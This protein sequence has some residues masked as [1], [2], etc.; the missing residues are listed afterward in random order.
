[1]PLGR[2]PQD[3][4]PSIPTPYAAGKV[5]SS[6]SDVEFSTIQEGVDATAAGG[7][8]VVGPGTYQENVLVETDNIAI[9]T[10]RALVDG[11][12]DY[13]F[14]LLNTTG[15]LV[16]GFRVQ[17]NSGA[18][19]NTST[20]MAQGSNDFQFNAI[21][22]L[23]SGQHGFEDVNSSQYTGKLTR[24]NIEAVDLTCFY[25]QGSRYAIL[26]NNAGFINSSTFSTGIHVLAAGANHV[27]GYNTLSRPGSDGINIEGDHCELGPNITT[28]AGSAGL[29]VAGDDTSVTGGYYQSDAATD[30]NVTAGAHRTRLENVDFD[31]YSDSGIETMVGGRY[32]NPPTE[33]LGAA[34][35]SIAPTDNKL[36]HYRIYVDAGGAAA[37]LQ[38]VDTVADEGVTVTIVHAG[39]ETVTLAHK[40]G[41]A[42][43]PMWLQGEADFDLTTNEQQVTLEHDGSRWREISSNLVVA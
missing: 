36:E 1:M 6:D 23:D 34:D 29:S 42:T 30:L 2:Y 10:A 35:G 38:G 18:G 41:T 8:V 5:V 28:H 14:Y 3:A 43:N 19:N 12:N 22:V 15:V 31:T 39:G 24:W 27:I 16:D 7:A 9:V 20:I 4:F 13:C 17:N 21:S 40:D 32:L 33:D 37:T 11:Q 25:V 26:M